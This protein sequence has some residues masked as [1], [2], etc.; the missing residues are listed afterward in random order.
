MCFDRLLKDRNKLDIIA[1]MNE[2]FDF[3]FTTDQC[4]KCGKCIPVCTIHQVNPDETTSPRG[5]LHL[6]GAVA[7]GDLE[8]DKNTKKIFESCFLCTNCVSVCPLALP[9]DWMIEEIRYEV[10]KKYGITW[11]KKIFFWL[12]KHRTIMDLLAK[13]G[14]VVKSCA[15]SNAPEKGGMLSRFNLPIIKKNRLIPS[16][17]SQTFLNTY[18]EKIDFGG[19]K[20]VAIFIGCMANYVYTEVGDS[21]L[22]VLKQLGINVLIPKDQLCCGAPSWFTGDKENTKWLIKYNIEYF[23]MFIDTVEAVLVPEATCSSMIIHDWVRVL[24]GEDEWVARA[25]KIIAKTYIATKWLHDH[26]ELNKLLARGEKKATTVTY[27]DPCHARKTQ[28][29]WREPRSFIANGYE[30]VEMSDP[31]RCCG[32]GGVTIQSE[33]FELAQK[34][35]KPKADMIRESEAEVVSAEC[36]A[37]RVQLNEAMNSAGVECIFKHPVELIAQ[38]LREINRA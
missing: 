28:G 6:V 34:A 5:F 35:G 37:C 13:I 22:Y 29:V 36:S 32:F 18:P 26:T 3:N 2:P 7:E 16:P 10:A 4:I 17:K 25:E 21:L 38:S 30:L 15:F 1:S 11:F 24:K 20:Q 33:R 12:L 14:F 23:E 31:N 19:E 8:L 9:T 27:H